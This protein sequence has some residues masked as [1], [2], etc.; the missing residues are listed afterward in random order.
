MFQNPRGMSFL[1]VVLC[2]ALLLGGLVAVLVSWQHARKTG[3]AAASSSA[4]LMSPEQQ[5]YCS[6]LEFTDLRMSAAENFLGATVTYLDG[7]VSNKGA[8]TLHQVKVE[9]SFV[10]ALN[11]VVLRETAYPVTR[12]A[13]PLQPGVA[14]SF[15]VNFEHMPADWNQAP[16]TIKPIYMEF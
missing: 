11:Q 1:V 14:R 4:R 3:A 7:R 8:K 2:V 10:D 6:S 13:A 15:R 12:A 9:L 16:P 5:A